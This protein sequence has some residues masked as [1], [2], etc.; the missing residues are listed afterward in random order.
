[1]PVTTSLDNDKRPE[2]RLVAVECQHLQQFAVDSGE[3]GG[4]QTEVDDPG[5][6]TADEDQAAK[7]AV[8]SDENAL[9]LMGAAQDLGIGRSSTIH[10]AGEN[11]IVTGAPQCG[12]RHGI[13]IVVEKEPHPAAEMWMS[14]AST[15]SI[16]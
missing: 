12:G 10:F 14:S 13:D 3:G 11:Y 15:T 8:A 9:V 16:A 4:S 2:E 7:V 5:G 1:M 6:E